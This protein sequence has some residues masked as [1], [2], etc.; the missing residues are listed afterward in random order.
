[1]KMLKT[2]AQLVLGTLL[3]QISGNG[4]R[5]RLLL[6]ALACAIGAHQAPAQPSL[7]MAQLQLR[8][9]VLRRA[10]KL[11]AER[12][13]ELRKLEEGMLEARAGGWLGLAY[14]DL[15]QGLALL[16]SKPWGP[17][18]EFAASLRLTTD[19]TVNDPTH[20]LIARIGQYYPAQPEGNAQL[21]AHVFLANLSGLLRPGARQQ[22]GKPVAEF[23]GFPS[24]LMFEPFRFIVYL[25]DVKDGDYQ[26]QVEVR[27]GQNLIQRLN[28]PLH[29]V[30]GLDT[31]RA[32]IE[33]RLE[34]VK[35][36]EEV[37][38]SI[39]FPFDQARTVNLGRTSVAGYDFAAGI[40]RAEELLA[41]VESGKDPFA[42]ETGNLERHYFFQEADEIMPYR[43]Y[44]PRSYD[45]SKAYPLIVALHGL[46]GT[47]ATMF[48]QGNGGLPKLAEEHGYLVVSPLGYRRNG[49]YGRIPTNYVADSATTRMS[50]LSEQDV[51][52]VLDR[53]RDRYR[54]DPS[55]IYLMG[56]S[57]GGNGTWTLGTKYAQ[58]WAALAPIASGGIAPDSV[59]LA[60]LKANNIAVMVVH[61]DSDRTAPVESSRAMVA[62]LEKLGVP[63]EYVEVRRGTHVDVVGPNLA[64]I[65]AF[66]DQHVRSRK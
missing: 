13:A 53:V 17:T 22:A 57:M 39:F 6:V 40:A 35:G 60:K 49:G 44:V 61:G 58:V 12:E 28:I 41:G 66:F 56:H 36:F 51:I 5:S 30:R 20:P 19:M 33:R 34:A 21:S 42:G 37:K 26:L 55:R 46:G 62:E 16:E 2:L 29:L 14:R 43:L 59:P 25:D 50:R 23:T 3:R 24:D 1:M 11:D 18:E 27:D 8:Y 52:N 54:V 10:T 9:R 64:R 63:H 32:D 38:P 47:E 45:G 48:Q 4:I 7:E 31:K 15:S 65:V